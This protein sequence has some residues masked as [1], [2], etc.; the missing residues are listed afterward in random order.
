MDRMIYQVAVGKQSNLYEHCIKSVA[1]YCKK[2]NLKHIVQTEPILKIRPDVNR[3]GRSKEA[4]ERLG[5][6][7]IFEKENAFSYIVQFKQLAIAVSY[8]HLTLPTIYTV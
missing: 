7:P 2:Y 6:L 8:T 4:V 3:T 5:Y 1:N